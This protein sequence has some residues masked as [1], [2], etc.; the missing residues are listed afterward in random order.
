MESSAWIDALVAEHVKPAPFPEILETIWMLQRESPN[1]IN[2]AAI[3][4]T[5]PGSHRNMK[6]DELRE[7][8]RV[9]VRMVPGFVSL[10]SD[11]VVILENRPDRIL[12]EL[13]LQA[14]SLPEE[15]RSALYR[16]V[17]EEDVE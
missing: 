3:A 14:E 9:L 8:L 1:P 11:D 12:R 13:K 2:V 16:A 5:L 7:L 15:L 10:N 4:V 6:H 17:Y